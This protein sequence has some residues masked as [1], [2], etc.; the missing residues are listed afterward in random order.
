MNFR[1][2]LLIGISG[3]LIL[4]FAMPVWAEVETM[5]VSE[6]LPGMRG[7][8]KTV[9]QGTEIR[10]FDVE[11]I[12][13]FRNLGPNG[14]PLIFC[15]ISG[16]VV[17]ESGGIAGGYSGSPVY[18]DGKL[19]GALSWGA[20]YTEGDVCGATPIHEMLRTFT[21]PDEDPVRI[22]DVP[23]C[24]DT[25]MDLGGRTVDSVYLAGYDD[26][27]EHLQGVFG[28]ETLIMRPCSTPLIVSGLSDTGFRELREFAD[29]RLPYVELIKGPGSGLSDGIPTMLGPVE[30]EGGASI[31]AQLATG[32]LELTAVGT[33]TWVGDDGRFLAFGHPFL[34]DGETNIPF[35]T[36]EIIYTMPSEARSFKMGEPLEVVGTVTQDRLSCIGGQLS[37]VPDLVDFHLEVKDY[38]ID[39]TRRFDY[40]VIN[41]E[42]W[43]PMLGIMMPMEGLVYSS[44][45]SGPGTVKI[46]FSI[47]G[48]GLENPITRENLVW[49]GYGTSAALSEFMEA[50][51]MVTLGNP[52]REVKITRVEID[53]E[54]TS[55][56]QTMNIIRAR[57]Q[58][59]PN[60]G[61]GAIGYEGPSEDEADKE[62]KDAAI[63]E[64]ALWLQQ[65]P[66]TG[67]EMMYMDDMSMMNGYDEVMATNLVKYHPGDTIEVLVTL[68]PYREEP[69]EKVIELEI[70]DD[71]PTGQTSLEIMGGNSSGW[72]GGMIYYDS[73]MDG[74]YNY[75]YSPP[76][77]LDDNI[78]EFME[79]DHNNSIVLRLLRMGSDDPYFYLQDNYEEP[80]PVKAVLEMED[81]IFGYYSLPIEVVSEDYVD[82]FEMDEAFADA[83][84]MYEE[85]I[86][87]TEDRPTSR[88]PHRNID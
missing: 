53:V 31:G 62:A 5:T 79:R 68:R 88:N 15:R 46:N 4:A 40:S 2:V 21:Y 80:E 6:V 75:Y 22:S 10:E 73:F 82:D 23:D 74:G 63:N 81:I 86:E 64:A 50:L 66:Y 59:A 20:Y 39:R 57:F 30:L 49:G 42:D 60:I 71:F 1:S 32:D 24:L 44:D 56:R 54:I 18:I 83:A 11:I 26:D 72:Y 7:I 85:M 37:M 47:Y 3:L 41:K 19:I 38:D 14:G 77:D 78:Q 29:E 51:N 76:E 35:I 55:A 13:V 16:D 17:D 58:N 34:A 25:P 61:P 12:D 48:E 70:P 28:D 33:L 84:L 27:I 8:A 43:L 67:E 65:A 52:F 87:E 69:V 9:I 36:T 45:R